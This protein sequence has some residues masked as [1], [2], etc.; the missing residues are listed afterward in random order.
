MCCWP[1]SGGGK[2]ANPS[3]ASDVRTDNH[4]RQLGE[5]ETMQTTFFAFR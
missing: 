4:D 5:V 2:N 3:Y 1:G